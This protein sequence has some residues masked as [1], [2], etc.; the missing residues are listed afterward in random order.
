MQLP[1]S[2]SPQL[3]PV[4]PEESPPKDA[5]SGNAAFAE[6]AKRSRSSG[7]TGSTRMDPVFKGPRRHPGLLGL[8]HNRTE[9]LL[10]ASGLLLFS[11]V[12][13]I[14]GATCLADPDGNGH[15]FGDFGGYIGIPLVV[16][17]AVFIG[18][19]VNANAYFP[20]ARTPNSMLLAPYM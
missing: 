19:V 11:V 18:L 20:A 1:L 16:F 14:I 15:P 2:P 8:L 12:L 10:A 5:L 3:L 7:S 4:V 17:G 13:I 9:F 6:W